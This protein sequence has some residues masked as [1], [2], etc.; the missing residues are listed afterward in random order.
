M[1]YLLVLCL[2]FSAHSY[3]HSNTKVS[4][5]LAQPELLIT[6]V[7]SFDLAHTPMLSDSEKKLVPLMQAKLKSQQFSALYQ[8]LSTTLNNAPVS[9]AMAYFLGQLNLQLAQYKKAQG[10]FASASKQQPNYAKAIVGEGM[11]AL[12]LSQYKLATAKFS[13]ALQLGINDPH[14][15]RY[16]GFS[17]LEQAQFL[18]ATIAFERAKLLLPEDEQLNHALIYSYSNSGQLSPALAMIEQQLKVTPNNSKLWLQRANIYLAKEQF[19][20]AIASLETALRL[21]EQQAENIA[22]AA[23][24]QLQYGSTVRAIALYQ[25]IWQ[26]Q[27]NTELVL[28]A[29]NYLVDSHKLSEA[30]QLLAS[31]KA[32]K[33]KTSKAKNTKDQAEL[34]YLTGKLSY[35]QSLSKSHSKSQFKQ[36]QKSLQQALKLNPIHGNALMSLAKIYRTSDDSH[37]AQ[38]LLLRA[39]ELS[40]VKLQALTEHADLQLALGNTQKALTLLRQALELAPNEQTLVNNVNTLQSMVIQEQATQLQTSHQGS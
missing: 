33:A 15:Y 16:L 21:G 12:Q 23:Q 5:N 28:E 10:Y 2:L 7:H 3:S 36:A 18:S 22:L 37:R 31:A 26:R 19:Q 13:Q 17:Y 6:Q 24:L 38:M 40:E 14:L 39:A 29:I 30:K 20:T 35:Q 4:I 1:R 32:N 27:A 34:L 11:A 25:Q 9:A 8:E